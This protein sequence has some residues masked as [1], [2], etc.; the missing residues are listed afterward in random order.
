MRVPR[1]QHRG[2]IR[3]RVLQKRER[4]AL[5]QSKRIPWKQLAQ[6]VEEYTDWQVFGLWLRAL[7]E[8]ARGIPAVAAEELNAR[9]PRFVSHTPTPSRAS[10]TSTCGAGLDIWQQFS[11][12]VEKEKFS[13][14]E[15]EGW[16]DAIRHFSSM[17][18]RSMQ[19]WAHWEA[20]D[21]DW[22]ATP[23]QAYPDYSLWKHQVAGVE[24][25]SNIE[26]P[27]QRVLDAVRRLPD[28]EWKNLLRRFS[29]S[30]AFL[31]W[32]ELII[33][34]DGPK[35]SIASKELTSRFPGFSAP[36]RSGARTL[37]RALN[38]WAMK[39][40][41]DISDNEETLEALSFHVR[42]HPEY[43]A[44]LQYASR[45]H[46]DWRGAPPDHLPSFEEWRAA[47]SEFA[48]T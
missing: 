43:P 26:S 4:L 9:I 2:R 8:A 23:P 47:A 13:D 1:D 27:A 16:L 46:S 5:E 21:R 37:V 31:I 7:V 45:C 42:N 41:L 34:I 25:L 32:L 29:E 33:E 11:L 6:A 44:L 30:M 36:R 20:V 38:Q 17:S 10:D 28:P 12:F 39:H 18:L 22:R 14:S 3:D 35:S 15:R 40:Q 24:R 48:E 19:A